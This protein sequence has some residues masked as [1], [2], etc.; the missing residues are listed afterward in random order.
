MDAI[1][2]VGGERFRA[3]LLMWADGDT[4][5]TIGQKGG[6]IYF[7]RSPG[8]GRDSWTQGGRLATFTPAT[9]AKD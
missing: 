5:S 7:H 1:V 2:T 4:I 3:T 9:P 8:H 6:V